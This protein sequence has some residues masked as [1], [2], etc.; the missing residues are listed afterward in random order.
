MKRK[1]KKGFTIVEL[2]VVIAVLAILA[3]VLIP[4]FANL[5]H[6][7]EFNNDQALVRNLNT[8]LAI[9]AEGKD[10]KKTMHET[11]VEVKEEGGFIVETLTPRST[12]SDIVWDQEHNQFVLV[13]DNGTK[14]FTGTQWD[15]GLNKLKMWKIVSEIPT[16]SEYSLYLRSGA[17]QKTINANGFGVD[18]GS[19]T[20][21]ETVYYT[22]TTGSEKSVLIRTNSKATTLNIDAKD[23]TVDHHG[24]VGQVNITKIDKTHCYNEH[25]NAVYVKVT[26]GKVVAKAGGR[27]D[28]VYA[29]TESTTA[30]KV[31]EEETGKIGA[32]YTKTAP[33]DEANQGLG[34]I[35]LK[36]A[37]YFTETESVSGS[38]LVTFIE[39]MVDFTMNTA[40]QA[41]AAAQREK[42]NG[43]TGSFAEVN[44]TSGSHSGQSGTGDV[45]MNVDDVYVFDYFSLSDGLFDIEEED[46][47]PNYLGF[48]PI[49]EYCEENDVDIS[50]VVSNN[51]S[52]VTVYLDDE[53]DGYVL[54]GISEGTAKVTVTLTDNHTIDIMVV[55]GESASDVKLYKIGET[56]CDEPEDY[57][58]YIY[59]STVENGAT[60][61]L[62]SDYDNIKGLTFVAYNN[63]SIIFDLAGCYIKKLAFTNVTV[64][65]ID[66]SEEKTGKVENLSFTCDY[67]V[68]NPNFDTSY[69]TTDVDKN[70]YYIADDGITKVYKYL[71]M[72]TDRPAK[73]TLIGGAYKQINVNY[74]GVVEVAG[75]KIYN[76]ESVDDVSG[77]YFTIG[78]SG[79]APQKYMNISITSGIIVGKVKYHSVGKVEVS[80]GVFSQSVPSQYLAQ[81]YSCVQVDGGYY[82]V[83]ANN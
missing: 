2:V 68:L 41:E 27:I 69:N 14:F 71:E 44:F 40:K 22:N 46:D 36:T 39:N 62:L 61:T 6:K 54:T 51:P 30:V 24:D 11:L 50:S 65:I 73:M 25:G 19:N 9:S 20:D 80:G 15:T 67:G 13:Y 12:G 34:G 23:D 29:N 16:T 64:T 21:V 78:N 32:G 42:Q 43:P 18:V 75:A 56:E 37:V 1:L 47:D 55:V 17:T 7:A 31:L 72:W 59:V 70:C 81:G 3:A 53:C 10:G 82:R 57:D 49:F 77:M 5:I 4:T 8:T 38:G 33:V 52:C 83:V 63:K 58:H 28:I 26:E 79:S 48:V 66:S 60:I 35:E 45:V 76:A 74:I